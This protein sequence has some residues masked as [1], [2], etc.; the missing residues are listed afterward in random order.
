MAWFSL[1]WF[2]SRHSQ[3]GKSFAWLTSWPSHFSFSVFEH[4]KASPKDSP[5]PSKMSGIEIL[6]KK[7]T[8]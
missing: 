4:L 3:M 5:Y 2:A 7:T 6:G 1:A 8:L